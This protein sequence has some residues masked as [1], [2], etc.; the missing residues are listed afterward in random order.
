MYDQR[1]AADVLVDPGRKQKFICAKD[2]SSDLAHIRVGILRCLADDRFNL[3]C[4]PLC[5]NVRRVAAPEVGQ[6]RLSGN[7]PHRGRLFL[8]MVEEVGEKGNRVGD[9]DDAKDT[10]FG[11]GY[12]DLVC[13]SGECHERREECRDERFKVCIAYG[14][15]CIDE[16]ESGGRESGAF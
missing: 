6:G 11:S 7:E 12:D 13:P 5:F 9:I 16:V 15:H 3:I 2:I 14:R 1:W 8:K 10:H 4:T